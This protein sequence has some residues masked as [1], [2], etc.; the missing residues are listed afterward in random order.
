MSE[1]TSPS[2]ISGVTESTA[3]RIAA[4][5]GRGSRVGRS[6]GRGPRGHGKGGPLRITRTNFR[7]DTEAMNGHVFE[8]YDEQ[9]D[10]RQY[11]KTRDAL[12]GYVKKNL[13]F[14]EDLLPLFAEEMEE[15]VL[16]VL[17]ELS[18]NPTT[19]EKAIWDEEVK[20]YVKRSRIFKG[21]L[22]I[23][24]AVILGQCSES[25]KERLRSLTD[26]KTKTKKNDCFWLLQQIRAVTLK[27]DEKISGFLSIMDA[28]R[29]FLNCKQLPGQSADSYLQDLRGWA[30]TISYHDGTIVGNYRLV[31]ENDENGNVRTTAERNAIAHDRTLAMA[32]VTRADPTRYGAL[33]TNLSNQFANGKDEY[34]LDVTSAYGLLVNYRNPENARARNAGYV[35][36]HSTSA[37][38][39]SAM[40]F[41]QQA[42]VPGNNGITHEGVQCYNCQSMGHYASNCN[43][44]G[45]VGTTLV[46]H[47]YMMAQSDSARIDPKWILLDSQSTISVFNNRHMLTNIR[48]SPHVLRAMTNGGHQDSHMIGDFANLGTV[49]YNARSIANILSLA[50][51]RKVCRVTMDTKDEP[52]LCVHRLDG[53]VMKF[54]EHASG[55]Y[56]YDSTADSSKHS[57]ER[58][59]AYTMIS[60]VAAQKQMFSRRE[61]AAADTAR[62]LYRKIGRPGE[63][64]FQSILRA[65]TIRN[66]PVS[67]DDAKRA[68]L[69][70]GPDVAVLK[71]K[72]TRTTAAPRAPT[73]TAVPLPAPIAQHHRNVTLC[74]DFFLC[75]ASLFYT[76]SRAVLVS[77]RL[78][79][80]M[81]GHTKPF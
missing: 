33:I 17:E 29:S 47:A 9:N 16:E 6:K 3:G 18:P 76:Q 2:T 48:K 66:C 44:E 81:T 63:H 4:G 20:E 42:L 52:S 67:P 28:Q 79:L 26:Y 77:A 62:E 27:F 70:Y 13:K 41:A 14:V 54:H 58:V 71:G 31:P 39:T 75:K 25:M 68:L 35:N 50:D 5:A 8:C 1:S 34:P 21:N 36:N 12:D 40:T 38:E 30:E 32:L 7:G 45:S 19:V 55:L 73:F 69:I 15:P 46:Q 59:T 24:Q 56:V 51:V 43:I 80:F 37:P 11:T 64:A 78:L 61:I 72:M 57:S 65:N 22:A 53:S 74:V 60:T 23:I 49:W 10:R